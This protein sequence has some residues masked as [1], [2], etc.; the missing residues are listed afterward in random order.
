MREITITEY[1]SGVITRATK[2]SGWTLNVNCYIA[3]GTQD[4]PGYVRLRIV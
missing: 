3:W 2:R 1:R 4:G